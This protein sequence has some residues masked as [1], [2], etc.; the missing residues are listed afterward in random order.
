MYTPMQPKEREYMRIIGIDPGYD[1]L[2]Y[3]IIEQGYQKP[4]VIASGCIVTDKN[5]HTMYDSF[6]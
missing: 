5:Y 3:A 2:G 1:R 6:H 4:H